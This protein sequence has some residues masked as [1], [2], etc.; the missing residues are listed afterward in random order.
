QLT[1][2][3]ERLFFSAPSNVVGQPST[4]PESAGKRTWTP[5]FARPSP[6]AS[7]RNSTTRRKS[8][9]VVEQVEPAVTPAPSARFVRCRTAG[10]GPGP[11]T[12]AR[13]GGAGGAGRP[14]GRTGTTASGT[15]RPPR[16]L[17]G[18]RRS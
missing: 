18:R 4:G 2:I 11:P 10:V 12:G 8:R 1:A 14:R 13:P 7:S 5:L 15:G 6:G 17:P 16:S 9:A 3:H